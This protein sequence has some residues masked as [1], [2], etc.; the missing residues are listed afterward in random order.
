MGGVGRKEWEG[1][2]GTW[3]PEEDKDED[4]EGEE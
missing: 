1:E 4:E 2:E 3:S